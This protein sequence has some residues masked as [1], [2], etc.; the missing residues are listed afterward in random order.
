MSLVLQQKL[1]IGA[2]TF[3]VIQKAVLESARDEPADRLTVELPRYKGFKIADIKENAAVSWQAGYEGQK[4]AD[5][6]TGQVDEIIPGTP[7]QI[8]AYDP[9]R[10]LM[11]RRLKRNFSKQSLSSILPQLGLE[12]WNLVDDPGPINL[13]CYGRSA[14]WVIWQLRRLGFWCYFE[15]G[16]LVIRSAKFQTKG[17]PPIFQFRKN[18]IKGENLKVIDQKQLQVVVRCEEPKSGSIKE[19]SFGE[20]DEKLECEVENMD[21]NSLEGRAKEL[22]GQLTGA[23]FEGSFKTFAVPS[24]RHSQVVKII[25]QQD[26]RRTRKA[27]VVRVVKEYSGSSGY[28]HQTIHLGRFAA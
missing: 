1:K 16:S 23:R 5:E 8:I 13:R 22:H 11:F 20:G 10:L 26:E 2:I 17:D 15:D 4:L 18:I 24:V 14:R 3:P 9:M 21:K 6:F 27:G 7:F 25:D 12:K 28:Y 19:V